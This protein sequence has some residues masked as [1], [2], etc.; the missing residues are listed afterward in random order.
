VR[1]TKVLGG[2]GRRMIMCLLQV[3]DYIEARI[4]FH[5]LVW[6]QQDNNR[7]GTGI[8]IPATVGPMARTVDDCA[9]FMKVACVPESWHGDLNAPNMPSDSATYENKDEKLDIG[10]IL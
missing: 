5:F 1:K 3:V 10:W 8:V 2:G 7:S 4:C 9:F 6:N